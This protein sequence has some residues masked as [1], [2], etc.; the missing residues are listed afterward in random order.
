MHATEFEKLRNTKPL[1]KMGRKTRDNYFII[2]VSSPGTYAII[3]LPGSNDRTNLVNEY[4][5]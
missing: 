2:V 1:I 4:D 5:I 3:S